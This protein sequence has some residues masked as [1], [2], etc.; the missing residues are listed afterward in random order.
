MI[1][2][3]ALLCGLSMSSLVVGQ[4]V[5]N[6]YFGPNCANSVNAPPGVPMRTQCNTSFHCTNGAKRLLSVGTLS[7][8]CPANTGITVTHGAVT[9]TAIGQ[10]SAT[11]S[12]GIVTPSGNVVA[13]STGWN[14]TCAGLS[15]VPTIVGPNSSK[16]TGGC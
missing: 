5:D 12:S 1:K 8:A 11:G 15:A 7:F 6:I 2:I 13:S 9:Q 3:L 14:L 10:I 4:T 16:C